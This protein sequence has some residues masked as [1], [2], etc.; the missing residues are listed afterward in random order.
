MLYEGYDGVRESGLLLCRERS[1]GAHRREVDTSDRR[2]DHVEERRVDV[3][4]HQVV[5][6]GRRHGLTATV[7][8]EETHLR[9]L[10]DQLRADEDAAPNVGEDALGWFC[11]LTDRAGGR[12]G[13][14]ST[15]GSTHWTGHSATGHSAT[16][17][18]ANAASAHGSLAHV[19]LGY[20][21]IIFAARAP[22]SGSG[23]A[24][25]LCERADGEPT[26]G[27]RGG[28][29]GLHRQAEV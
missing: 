22:H 14:R 5:H 4:L 29:A 2:G 17:N 1:L 18:D 24:S 12:E 13:D 10:I 11:D 3:L 9:E 15:D 19:L 21:D 25:D 28:K 20:D 27:Y 8:A 26:T 7:E 23:G 16:G 6:E